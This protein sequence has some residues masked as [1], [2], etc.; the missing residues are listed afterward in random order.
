MESM[1]MWTKNADEG[2]KH[3]VHE[4]DIKRMNL[5]IQYWHMYGGLP[6]YIQL[7]VISILY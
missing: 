4:A 1:K 3:I 5:R 7:L 2:L 6:L